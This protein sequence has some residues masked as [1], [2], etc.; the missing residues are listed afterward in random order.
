MNQDAQI[1]H[2]NQE[3]LNDQ[4]LNT[5]IP[6]T[7]TSAVSVTSKKEETEIKTTNKSSTNNITATLLPSE[8]VPPP[9]TNS[10]KKETLQWAHPR[11]TLSQFQLYETK[12][13]TSLDSCIKKKKKDS[14]FV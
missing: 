5:Q 3:V 11:F 1:F 12:T 13:V 14:Y 9:Q 4:Y 7:T 2:D 8:A 6:E 10:K